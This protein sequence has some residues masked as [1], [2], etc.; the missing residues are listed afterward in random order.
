MLLVDSSGGAQRHFDQ[1]S[2]SFV[3]AT[4]A[5]S[6]S[7]AANGQHALSMHNQIQNVLTGAPLLPSAE[8]EQRCIFDVLPLSQPNYLAAKDVRALNLEMVNRYLHL[9]DE[10][11]M[12]ATNT[13]GMLTAERACCSRVGGDRCGT[14][15]ICDGIDD[16]D[17]YS[18]SGLLHS[19]RRKLKFGLMTTDAD[20]QIDGSY[21]SEHDDPAYSVG[22][23]NPKTP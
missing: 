21:G 1:A 16:E 18:S 5:S 15:T 8:G 9:T 4:C 3:S 12:V 23:I 14:W 17:Q 13:K 22:A 2:N 19:F 20:P 10:G 7:G 11:Q 6:A